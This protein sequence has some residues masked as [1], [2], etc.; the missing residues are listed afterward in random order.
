[1][2]PLPR[3]GVLHGEL[4][5]RRARGPA[6]PAR[7]Q[8]RAGVSP[9]T[10]MCERLASLWK[11]RLWMLGISSPSRLLQG[12]SRA[13]EAGSCRDGLGAAAGLGTPWDSQ[14]LQLGQALKLPGENLLQGV[15]GNIPERKES[16]AVFPTWK[17]SEEL[18]VRTEG[19][20]S[21]LLPSTPQPQEGRTAPEQNCAAPRGGRV[22]AAP[23]PWWL[24]A[25]VLTAAAGRPGH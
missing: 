22:L 14:G 5:A 7:C 8:E 11:V 10:H 19:R 13:G 15:V 4:Q 3:Q 2:P 20:L 17:L 9:P 1:M 16:G 21:W 24:G 25:P 12:K 18:E 6:P 23:S